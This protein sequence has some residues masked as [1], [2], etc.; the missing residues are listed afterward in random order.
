MVVIEGDSQR[1]KV[2]EREDMV[3]IETEV[4]IEDI[5]EPVLSVRVREGQQMELLTV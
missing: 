4:I 5:L 3:P 2:L 1:L